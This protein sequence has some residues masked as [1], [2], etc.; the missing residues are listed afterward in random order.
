MPTCKDRLAI[1]ALTLLLAVTGVAPASADEPPALDIAGA[2]RA[3]FKDK[4]QATL[5]R[6]EQDETQRLCSAPGG[7]LS[8]AD[9]S[10][11]VEMN[12]ATLAAPS[13]GVY[14]GDHAAGERVAMTGSGLQWNDD[15]SKPNG[16]NCYACHEMAA[17]ELAYGTL[18]PSLKHYGKLRGASPQMLEYTWN[19]IYNSNALVPCSLMPRFGHQR[20]LTEQQM[21]DVMAYLFANDSPVNQ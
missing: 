16:G 8:P 10:R 18:G 1:P 12:R 19:K 7:A 9:A 11:I 5:S 3:S 4:K 2:M 21:K 14:L 13:D 17:K 6:L 20:I 15:P